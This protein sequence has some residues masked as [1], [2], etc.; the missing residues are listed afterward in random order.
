M[1]R[2]RLRIPLKWQV[3]VVVAFFVAAL[4]ALGITSMSVIARERRRATA[5]LV[6]DSAGTRLAQTGTSVLVQ[7]PRWPEDPDPAFWAELDRVLKK[8]ATA[9]L[10]PFKGVEGGYY[11]RDFNRFVGAAF[12]N[13]PPHPPPPHHPSHRAHFPHP[14]PPPPPPPYSRLETGAR[15]GDLPTGPPHSE[16][17]LI[18]ILVDAAIR[19]QQSQFVVEVSHPSV[20]A[21]RTSPVTIRGRIVAATWAMI[22]L[23]DPLFVNRS[24]HG[25]QFA[26]GM[27]LGGIAL[28]FGLMAGLARTVRRQAAEREQLQTELRRSERLAA[29]GKL[30]AGVAHEVRNPLTGI[31]STVQLWQRGIGPDDESFEGLVEEVDRLE[32]IVA[33]LL[34]F[35]RA[36]AQ[37][38]LPSNLNHVIS[39]VARLTSSQA[40]GQGV[41]IKLDLD[42]ELPNIL[43]APPAIVQVFRN[44]SVNALQAM[45]HGGTLLLSTRTDASAGVV[46]AQVVDTGPGLTPEVRAHLFEPF[47]TTKAGGT[48]LGLA[49]AREIALAHRGDLR[50]EVDVMGAGARFTLTLPIPMRNHQGD[51]F[52]G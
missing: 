37:D 39:E 27:A 35:S 41:Q 10:T 26:A 40:D 36:D 32:G 34:Q 30:L 20:V 1:A 16:V 24:I 6:L 31:R 9:A 52:D 2:Q 47:Y 46:E 3:G 5:K 23:E 7:P 4:L 11:V 48:G 29:L 42:P 51:G 22:R 49:I 19:K 18:E 21:I 17:E 28:S 33:R 38:L 44:L 12:P 15:P 8:Q 14:P 50:A 45:P 13:A 43:M 25:F